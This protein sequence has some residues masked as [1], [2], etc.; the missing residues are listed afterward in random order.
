M[1]TDYFK[2]R[3]NSYWIKISSKN[4]PTS[5][6][7][8]G[9]WVVFL[10]RNF[11]GI[12]REAYNILIEI[13]KFIVEDNGVLGALVK[14]KNLEVINFF[15]TADRDEIWRVK[16][17][18][19]SELEIKK[20]DLIWKANFETKDDWIFGKGNLW[21]ISEIQS[22]IEKQTKAL[23]Q[24]RKTKAK[25]IQKNAIDPLFSRFHKKL[26]EENTMNH[27]KMVVSPAFPTGLSSRK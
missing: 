8:D 7:E 5:Q 25:S 1:K 4:K 23:I 19:I 14:S 21:F 15:T 12:K 16:K 6:Q 9:K 10:R 20:S 13:I 17:L 27:N 11:N 26:L 18:I 24:G 2:N 3:S 22:S